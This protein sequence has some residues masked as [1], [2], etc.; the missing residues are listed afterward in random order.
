MIFD[1]EQ[2]QEFFSWVDK[3]PVTGILVIIGTAVLF[4]VLLYICYRL[5][6]REKKRQ[7][8][9]NKSTSY[10]WGINKKYKE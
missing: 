1:H 2:M 3:N 4:I 7:E 10:N 5:D 8:R 9:K 6:E